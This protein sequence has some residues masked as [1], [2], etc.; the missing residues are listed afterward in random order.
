MAIFFLK[1]KIKLMYR[2]I[3][4]KRKRFIFSVL[5]EVKNQRKKEKDFLFFKKKWTSKKTSIQS[6]R[7][8]FLASKIDNYCFALQIHARTSQANGMSFEKLQ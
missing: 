4:Q 2:K 1:K 8:P 7:G 6:C 3:I 5:L